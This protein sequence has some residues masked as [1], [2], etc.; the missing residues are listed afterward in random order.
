MKYPG[1]TSTNIFVKR[2]ENQVATHFVYLQNPVFLTSLILNQMVWALRRIS[3]KVSPTFS[4]GM[5]F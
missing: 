4:T 5:S 3:L 1:S 2:P